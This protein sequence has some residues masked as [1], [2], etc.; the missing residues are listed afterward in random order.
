MTPRSA[1]LVVIL[2]TGAGKGIDGKEGSAGIE[3]ICWDMFGN[4]GLWIE[5]IFDLKDYHW[6]LAFSI[7]IMIS[8]K[9]YN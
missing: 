5:A 2:S 3:G 7:T 9:I 6:A 4:Y 1:I 8:L